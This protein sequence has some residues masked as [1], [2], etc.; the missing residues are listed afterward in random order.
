MHGLLK[1]LLHNMISTCNMHVQ[2]V[3][4]IHC[5][6]NYKC[7]TEVLEL[8]QVFFAFSTTFNVDHPLAG[9]HSQSPSSIPSMCP[10]V[11]HRFGP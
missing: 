5:H 4:T 3:H 7:P 1:R 8:L 11:V 6:F 9:M 2:K 10:T